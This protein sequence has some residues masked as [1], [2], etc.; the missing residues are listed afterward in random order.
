MQIS[1]RIRH[2][3]GY[4][5]QLHVNTLISHLSETCTEEAQTYSTSWGLDTRPQ[6]GCAI[7]PESDKTSNSCTVPAHSA[8]GGLG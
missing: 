5:Q 1:Q 8:T 7:D 4:L 3:Q 6:E 2:I